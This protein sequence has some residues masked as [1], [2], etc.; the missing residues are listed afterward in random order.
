MEIFYRRTGIFIMAM[1]AATLAAAG[2]SSNG[3]T[4]SSTLGLPVQNAHRGSPA[5]GTITEYGIPRPQK[6]HPKT[7]PV[8]MTLGP[9]GA[10]WFAERGLGRIGRITT[11]GQITDQFKLTGK[12]RFPQNLTVGPDGNLWAVTGSTRT[13][14]KEANGAPDPYGAVVT[15]TTAGVVTGVTKLPMYSDPRMIKVGSDGN[16]WFTETSGFIG[17]VT[18][19]GAAVGQLKEFKIPHHHAAY[20]IVAGPD[21]NLWFVETDNDAIGRITTTGT[22]TIFPVAKKCGPAAIAVG[23]DGNLWASEFRTA[24]LAQVS[25]SGTILREVQLPAGS[26]PK[27]I[28][29]GGDGNLYVAE[30]GTGKIAVVSVA[31][32]L[33]SEISPPTPNSGPWFVAPDSHGNIWFTESL[34]GKI[35]RLT[36]VPN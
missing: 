27:G 1:C 24:R 8:G 20:G 32:V 26:Y 18:T 3:G 6:K 2:C 29:V 28:A 4:S 7:F 33:L 16:L 19:A 25:T 11:A 30:F 10:M 17:S 34:V 5:T 15:M 36:L 13:Y 14:R 22:V 12:A 31:G 21:G 35:G 23:P 9:D